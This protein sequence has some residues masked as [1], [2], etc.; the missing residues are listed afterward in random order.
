MAKNSLARGRAREGNLP[1]LPGEELRRSYRLRPRGGSRL[2][3]RRRRIAPLFCPHHE[4]LRNFHGLFCFFFFYF[5]SQKRS[6]G[7]R[8]GRIGAA[9]P[10]ARVECGPSP[11]REKAHVYSPLEAHMFSAQ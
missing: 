4:K 8:V 10:R 11:T 9:S 2:R 3:R 1:L 7:C 5:S 6:R